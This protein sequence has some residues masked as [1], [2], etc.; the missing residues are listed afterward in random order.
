MKVTVQVDNVRDLVDSAGVTV[1]ALA[2]R[3]GRHVSIASLKLKGVKPIFMDEIGAIVGAIN[4]A[5]RMTVTEEQ[6][7]KLIGRKNIKVRGFA[8]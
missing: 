4:A 2:Q 3:M 7:I 6:V 8:G 5:G 1:G